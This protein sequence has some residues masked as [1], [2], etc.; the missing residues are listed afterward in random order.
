MLLGL[1]SGPKIEKRALFGLSRPAGAEF[2][3]M[4]YTMVF[5]SAR[6]NF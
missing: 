4:T 5:V 3:K 2:S 1:I 6:R